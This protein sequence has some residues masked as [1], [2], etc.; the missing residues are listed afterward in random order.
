MMR[1]C[2]VCEGFTEVIFV[3]SCLAPHLLEHG[4]CAYPT[5]LR[6]PSGNHRGGRVTVERLGRFVSHELHAAD[7]ITTLVDYYGF[8]DA[9]GRSCVQLEQDIAQEVLRLAPSADPRFI[10]P[11]IQMYEFEGLLFSDVGQFHHVLDGWA[12]DVHKTL[13]D[14]RD[15]FSTPED[16]NNSP[17]TAPSKRI[18]AAFPP[19]SY[20]KAEHGPLIADAIGLET[21]RRQCPRFSTWLSLLEAWCPDG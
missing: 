4:V 13:T 1:I 21:M 5:L 20:G 10:R 17:Q 12:P 3:K 8:S 6:A 15:E 7:R 2:V 19:G 11:H 14:I 9:R 16:I 18:L